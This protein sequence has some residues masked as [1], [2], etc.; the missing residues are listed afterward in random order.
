MPFLVSESPAAAL[1]QLRR[2]PTGA[3]TFSA[4]MTHPESGQPVEVSLSPFHQVH[5][6]RYALYWKVLKPGDVVAHLE[7][8]T[9]NSTTATSFIGDP[10]AERSRNLQ[11]ESTTSGNFSGRNWRDA[12]DG[13]WFSYRLQAASGDEQQLVCTYWGGE[14]I[15]RTF[16]ILIEDTPIAAQ[17]LY[18]NRPNEFFDV[19]YRI[20]KDLTRGKQFVTVR[21]QAPSDG[22]AGGVFDVRIVN[23]DP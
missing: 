14:T 7:N 10:E 8:Q 17:T 11:G 20:P 15:K 16:D 23:A 1:Q 4:T 21:F 9:K 2:N 13:G 3:L 19:A 6:Q 12:R 22:K 18:Q 5:H